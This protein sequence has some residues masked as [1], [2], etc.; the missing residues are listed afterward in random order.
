MKNFC[1]LL[2]ILTF[3]S[4]ISAQ[5]QP[6]NECSLEFARNLVEQQANE[7]KNI[8]STNKRLKILTSV[9]EF[10]WKSDEPNARKYLAEAFEFADSRFKINGFEKKKIVENWTTTDKDYR[11]EVINFIGKYDIAWAKKLTAKVLKDFEE[12]DKSK[13]DDYD[14]NKEIGDVLDF[15]MKIYDQNPQFALAQLRT[16]LKYPL[17]QSWGFVLVKL[18]EKNQQE[19]DKLYSEL[20]IRYADSP[21]KDLYNLS[22]YPFGTGIINSIG[23]SM[24]NDVPKSFVP[25]PGLQRQFL[26]LIL[27]RAATF[28]PDN[29]QTPPT[30]SWEQPDVAYLYHAL[31]GFEKIVQ[32]NFSDL[33]E[34][35]AAAKTQILAYLSEGSLKR[36]SEADKWQNEE[37]TL[38][39]KQLEALQKDDELGKLTDGNILK[40]IRKARKEEEF[41]KAESWLDKI[42]DT[43]LRESVSLFY[44]FERTELAIKEKRLYEARKLSS[45]I[46]KI[47]FRAIELL[48]I[49]EEKLKEKLG[50]TESQDI[51]LEVYQTAVK[52]DNSIAKAQVLFSLAYV[53]EKVNHQNAIN[54]LSESIQTINALDNTD[55]L[56][57]NEVMMVIQSNNFTMTT[58]ISS[59][60]L[61]LE[62]VI[63]EIS[64]NDFSNTLNYANS[65]TKNYFR[66]LAVIEVAKNCKEIAKPK[67][68]KK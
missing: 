24:S 11:F 44:Y 1:T 51:L 30:N 14:K 13:R 25:N 49:A 18:A 21:I 52:A 36:I 17:S 65:F 5:Q 47:D 57:S 28:E 54:S 9:A 15:A 31:R 16:A 2:F 61:N 3:I 63:K 40:L 23:S 32:R 53:Y 6:K 59:P 50:K 55:D 8:E 20:L 4:I 27:Q 60:G 64:R 39:E 7:S 48:K 26:S 19:A 22:D 37:K 42:K 43:K 58:S 10:L 45:K 62:N 12:E 29:D 34:N 41:A 68:V 38:F 33:A 46:A 56:L 66:A 35:W 67:V